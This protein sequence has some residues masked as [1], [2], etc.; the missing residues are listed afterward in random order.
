MISPIREINR[1]LKNRLFA[2]MIHRKID[3][4]PQLFVSL[5]KFEITFEQL[6]KLTGVIDIILEFHKF[7]KILEFPKFKI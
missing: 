4:L 3:V 5:I 2:K 6:N 1:R 7:K